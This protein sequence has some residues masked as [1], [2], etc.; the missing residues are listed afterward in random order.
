[1]NRIELIIWDDLSNKQPILSSIL[2]SFLRIS[3]I[4]LAC[5]QFFQDLIFQLVSNGFEQ[6]LNQQ[7]FWI[8]LQDCFSACLL[9]T[10]DAADERSSVDL[11]GRRIIKKKK[12]VQLSV[13][14][15]HVKYTEKNIY[16]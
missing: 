8:N 6:K 13:R 15:S 1:M 4:Q 16:N 3:L 2:Y 11:G 5:L 10:S 12:Y 9:Y 14:Y 7:K